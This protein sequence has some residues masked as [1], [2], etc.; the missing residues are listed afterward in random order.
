VNIIQEELR[1]TKQQEK[2]VFIR[3]DKGRSVWG[4]GS[5]CYRNY[6]PEEEGDQCNRTHI[7][8]WNLGLTNMKCDWQELHF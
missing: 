4:L 5:D 3:E 7:T 2:D 1:N 6:N 8:K